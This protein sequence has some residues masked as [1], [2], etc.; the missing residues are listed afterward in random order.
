MLE[1]QDNELMSVKR[2]KRIHLNLDEFKVKLK[3][4]SVN[5]VVLE[6]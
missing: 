3:P 2:Q 6:R 1:K 5:V 4:N